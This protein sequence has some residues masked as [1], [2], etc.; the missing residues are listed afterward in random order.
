MPVSGVI[1]NIPAASPLRVVADGLEN[2]V[3]IAIVRDG[4]VAIAERGGRILGVTI[5]DASAA[6]EVWAT[7][8]DRDQ[9][10]LSVAA[11]DEKYLFAVYLGRESAS[12]V[13]Y[14]FSSRGLINRSVIV[15]GLPAANGAAVLR[16]GPD[17]MLYLALGAETSAG[18][19]SGDVGS[20]RGK[21]LRLNRDGSLPRDTPAVAFA[22]SAYEPRDLVWRGAEPWM[23]SASE[24]GSVTLTPL[25]PFWSHGATSS[26]GITLP[27]SFGARTVLATGD[28]DL[29]VSGSSS[30]VTM[31]IAAL[32]DR[33][34]VVGYALNAVPI[35]R[36]GRDLKNVFI[37]TATALII[38][39]QT[40]R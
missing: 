27:Q 34:S 1:G 38:Q 22:P 36:S 29:V 14:A 39:P 28:A 35:I 25:Q 9:K 5:D 17:G 30:S 26:T 24:S 21:V 23:L 37:C 12:L 19:M 2:P 7:T 16:Q 8:I 31:R 15:D 3:D 33:V 18:E 13:R 32:D 11:V 4:V 40:R 6:V 10:L 20:W